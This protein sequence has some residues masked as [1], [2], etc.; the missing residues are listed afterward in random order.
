MNGIGVGS[1]AIVVLHVRS[2]P[3]ADVAHGST[4]LRAGG[5]ADV[6]LTTLGG[7]PVPT[8]TA[9]GLPAGL[10]VAV[11]GRTV[12]LTGT[13]AAAGR[14]A[15][16]LTLDNGTGPAVTVPWTVEVQEP[17]GL[18]P[19]TGGRVL[20]GGTVDVPV[21]VSGYP[22]PEV[23]ADGL[24]AGLA[25]ERTATGVALRGTPTGPGTSHVRLT[26]ANGV[27]PAAV[28]TYALVVEAPATVAGTGGPL[29]AG[30][31]T[32]RALTVGGHPAPT[33]TTSPLP[34]WLT[35]DAAAATFTAEPTAADAGPV[36]PV[37]V[38]ADN[39]VGTQTLVLAFEVTSR[40][41]LTATGG[42]TRVRAGAP[43][44]VALADVV[45]HP[46]PAVTAAGLPEGLRVEVVDAAV[47]LR[48]TTSAP[49][50]HA[51]LLRLDN[52]TGPL[53]EVPWTVEVETPAALTADRSVPAVRGE[54][55]RV[56]VTAD[57]WPAPV[58]TADGLPEGVTWEPTPTGGRLVGT[59]VRAGTA[60]VTLRAANGVGAGATAQV[61]LVVAG[62]LDVAAST[63]R[64]AAGGA[65][66]VRAV[67][68]HP[69][70]EAEI[71]LHSAPRLLLRTRA[72]AAGALAVRV[73][74]P[75]DVPAGAHTLVVRSASGVVGG[76]PI[77]VA[78]VP[79]TAT[80]GP[81]G[82]SSGTASGGRTD[83]RL[84]ATGTTT[85]ALALTALLALAV[86]TASLRVRR[87][88]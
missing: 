59:P 56:D 75:A 40:P 65:V 48:G 69:H 2:A 63:A 45:G 38:T 5:T 21:T 61:A 72:D 28:A 71:W 1:S 84:A 19:A 35:F 80:T 74:L 7:H 32:T 12:R 51:V 49:G 11:D 23:S 18:T 79:G 67:G 27:G 46:R 57:G 52:G 50:P 29:A 30:T 13:T 17:P 9:D 81:S 16:T 85:G 26:A 86:G 64:P 15:V 3:S 54:P 60:T 39:G 70:E 87:R 41:T 77:E 37:T 4:T 44:D 43:A 55:V 73:H 62:G 25:L 88:A 58:V 82:T 22:E 20:L 76:V 24:P 6:A 83:A 42:T 34:R 33:L 8:V 10:D 36:P 14:H 68:L 31:R 66:D 53:V 47:H 78:A